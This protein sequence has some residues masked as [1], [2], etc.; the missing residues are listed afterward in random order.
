MKNNT[1]KV[2]KWIFRIVLFFILLLLHDANT[3]DIDIAGNT[4]VI[5]QVS[6]F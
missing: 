4:Y 2:T 6:N 5:K 3:L 1:K